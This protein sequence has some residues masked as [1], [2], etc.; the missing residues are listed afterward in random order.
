MNM[1]LL[2]EE[3][4]ANLDLSHFREYRPKGKETRKQKSSFGQALKSI[5]VSGLKSVLRIIFR[6]GSAFFKLAGTLFMFGFP[7]G[8][9]GIYKDYVAIKT[10]EVSWQHILSYM[11]TS[12]PILFIIMPFGLLVVS[13]NFSVLADLLE[14]H[15]KYYPQ[16]H[17]GV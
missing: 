8:I 14:P 7:L 16:C 17:G 15:A 6:I 11:Y 1:H 13:A 4:I 3:E 9:Y 5:C 12:L 10:H 2:T